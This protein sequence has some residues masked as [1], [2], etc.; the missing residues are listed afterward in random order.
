M[1]KAPKGGIAEDHIVPAHLCVEHA[2]FEKV[3]LSDLP[4]I[5]IRVVGKD[6]G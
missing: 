6:E 4:V 5:V 1:L 2:G 3:G